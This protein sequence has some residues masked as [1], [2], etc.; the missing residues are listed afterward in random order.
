MNLP[1]RIVWQPT[2]IYQPHYDFEVILDKEFAGEMF[3]AI[4]GREMQE[5]MN[6][7]AQKTLQRYKNLQPSPY[8]FHG[9][10]A[11]IRQVTIDGGRGTWLESEGYSGQ[12]PDFSRN[13]KYTTHNMDSSSDTLCLLSLFDLWIT[14]ADVL[15][16]K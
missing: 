1:N 7:L 11:L 3:T 13:L 12:P 15:K 9:N 16:G 10:S 5:K 8:H 6:S 4:I 14:Y 2:H